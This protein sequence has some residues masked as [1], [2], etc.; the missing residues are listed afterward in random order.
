MQVLLLRTE[1]HCQQTLVKIETTWFRRW[2]RILQVDWPGIRL[3]DFKNR[4]MDTWYMIN[5][6]KWY[7][8]TTWKTNAG[9]YMIQSF[10][11]TTS[12]LGS[13]GTYGSVLNTIG[14]KTHW[15]SHQSP[16][17]TGL[18]WSDLQVAEIYRASVPWNSAVGPPVLWMK[19]IEICVSC[20]PC[21]HISFSL[22]FGSLYGHVLKNVN[23]SMIYSSMH[24]HVDKHN[25]CHMPRMVE[26]SKK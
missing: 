8:K 21:I 25:S 14:R 6:D 11:Y 13:Y 23:D 24:T 7:M 17:Q 9:K 16:C 26:H 15:F 5:I 2:Y 3:Y 19:T 1:K 12:F 18:N 10:Y 22:V 20:M 4:Y